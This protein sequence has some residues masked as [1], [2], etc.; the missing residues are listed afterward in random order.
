MNSEL[1]IN[2]SCDEESD[3]KPEEEK[4]NHQESKSTLASLPADSARIAL[5]SF[6]TSLVALL[7]SFLSLFSSRVAAIK[8]NKVHVDNK[9][10]IDDTKSMLASQRA[11]IMREKQG[12][13]HME[14]RIKGIVEQIRRC[15]NDPVR[16]K[17]LREEAT[18]FIRRKK[19]RQSTLN[20]TENHVF[21]LEETMSQ[22]EQ[23]SMSMEAQNQMKPLIKNL[24]QLIPSKS[25]IE[26]IKNQ[27][28]KLIE[29][30]R[31]LNKEMNQLNQNII[32]TSEDH[33]LDEEDD[34]ISMNRSIDAE[35]DTYIE[36]IDEQEAADLVLELPDVPLYNVSQAP[37]YKLTQEESKSSSFAP[38]ITR[39]TES[40][41]LMSEF[42]SMD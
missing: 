17:K 34:Q 15:K 27:R 12:I 16:I 24:S 7:F 42:E 37:S 20:N 35:L 18:T 1:R 13:Y 3:V 11:F 6:F 33:H 5:S 23:F 28:L 26:K 32:Q 40:R 22:V 30:T 21:A 36:S 19:L 41:P 38:S 29:S 4:I 2:V 39:P 25:T 8:E 14:E 31:E 10:L 9:K